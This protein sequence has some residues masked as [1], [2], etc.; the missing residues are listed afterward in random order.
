MIVFTLSS[1]R[2]HL[3]LLPTLAHV[4]RDACVYHGG[5]KAAKC[6]S[7]CLL[8]LL[9]FLQQLSFHSLKLLGFTLIV[10]DLIL[11]LEGLSIYILP[12]VCYLLLYILILTLNSDLSLL[13]NLMLPLLC[14]HV[15]LLAHTI[16]TLLHHLLL[17]TH[18]L[19]N[20]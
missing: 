15:V 11:E 19:Y 18:L 16:E 9:K 13:F 20:S 4:L 8:C 2:L 14:L 17:L 7:L 10:R 6:I 1:I 3:G 12:C 5:L